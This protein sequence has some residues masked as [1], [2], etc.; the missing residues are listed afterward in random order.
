MVQHKIIKEITESHI[1]IDTFLKDNIVNQE[2]LELLNQ[3]SS[4]LYSLQHLVLKSGEVNYALQN[5]Y[6]E[7]VNKN[8]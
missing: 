4:R 2:S 5:K 3:V 6:L 7:R 8:E 1:L